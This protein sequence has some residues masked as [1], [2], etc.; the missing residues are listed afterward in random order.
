M[1]SFMIRFE[2]PIPSSRMTKFRIPSPDSFRIRFHG[3]NALVPL[4][5]NR[6]LCGQPQSL[7]STALFAVNCGLCSSGEGATVA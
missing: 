1:Y 5:L 7:R 4:L 2:E 3:M 6:S